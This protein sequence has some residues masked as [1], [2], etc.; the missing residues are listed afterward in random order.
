MAGQLRLKVSRDGLEYGVFVAEDPWAA[1]L[2]KLRLEQAGMDVEPVEQAQ[3]VE[4]RA[5]Q[6]ACDSVE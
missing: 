1:S 3:V 5:V 4:L 6:T 2:V